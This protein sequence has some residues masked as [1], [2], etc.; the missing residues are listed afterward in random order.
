MSTADYKVDQEGGNA[1]LPEIDF[2]KGVLILLVISFHLVFIEHKSP[3]AKQVVYTFHMPVFLIVSG[4]LMNVSKGLK[5]FLRTMAGFAVPYIVM[6]SCYVVAASLLPIN[7]HIAQLTAKV[8]LEKLFL[9]PIGLYWYLQ[10]LIVCGTSYYVVFSLPSMRLV[11]RILLLGTVCFFCSQVLTVISASSAFYFMT[12]VLLRLYGVRFCSFF[13]HS[14]LSL[15]AAAL[16]VFFPQNLVVMT[17]PSLLVVWLSVSI[18]HL[19]YCYLPRQVRK[20]FLFL[21]RNT[22]L[23]FLFSPIF[24]FACKLL[25]SYLLFEPTG[26]LFLILSLLFCVAGCTMIGWLMDR[27]HVSPWFFGR[28]QILTLL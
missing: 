21:G 17:V 28:K 15:P 16:L 20:P 23:L 13:S 6:E 9:H 26:L 24:T 11:S 3:Y 5:P 4:Y 25:S 8:F 7:E 1:R 2:L 27:L 12:G 22:M 18:V 14:L 10:T 19:L